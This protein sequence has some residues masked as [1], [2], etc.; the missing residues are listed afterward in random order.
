MKFAS[1][2]I[3]S[4]AAIASA[5][6]GNGAEGRVAA[7]GGD[8]TKSSMNL[9]EIQQQLHQRLALSSWCPS[10][11]PV[12][13]HRDMTNA[14]SIGTCINVADC[15]SPGYITQLECCKSSF[16]GQ[17]SGICLQSLPNPPTQLPTSLPTS[18]SPTAANT[19]IGKWYAD[20]STSWDVAGCKNTIPHP[21]YASVF[22]DTQLECCKS[23]YGGQM[24][25]ECLKGLPNPPTLSPTSLTEGPV[26]DLP[27]L[28]PTTK[29]EPA[30]VE[31]TYI[32]TIE[33]EAT[34][35]PTILPMNFPTLSPSLLTEGPVTDLSSLIPTTKTEPASVAET[36]IPTTIEPTVSDSQQIVELRDNHYQ[37]DRWNYNF[38]SKLMDNDDNDISENPTSLPTL[39]PSMSPII[40]E[41]TE[42]YTRIVQHKKG[43]EHHQQLVNS[44]KTQ[45]HQHLVNQKTKRAR[46]KKKMKVN[47]TGK[48][49]K[50]EAL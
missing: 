8:A 49:R 20:Y 28:W 17:V 18:K 16:G 41:D 33:I 5:Q 10:T 13:W 21:N 3:L 30:S 22:F 40:V 1:T 50:H 9:Q 46:Q 47:R 45:I 25:R 7:E 29:T 31:E 2:V 19:N 14:W 23:S 24:K 6:G 39:E 44:I 36:Y 37:H 42:D 12:L 27:S 11:T 35:L 48:Q 26:T 38:A 15:D 43:K 34:T 32:P 4:S